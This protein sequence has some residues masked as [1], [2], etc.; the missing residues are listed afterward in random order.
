MDEDSNR[1]HLHGQNQP[2]F[3]KV[4]CVRLP[5]SSIEEGLAFYRDALGHAVLWRTETAVGL[6]LPDSN[7]ELVLQTLGHPPEVDLTVD[8]VSEAVSLIQAAGGELKTGPFEVMIGLC[9][10]VTDPWSNR[11]VIL[12]SSKGK[13]Q[14]DPDDN[15][16]PRG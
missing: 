15:V 16:V 13:L 14:T 12:D 8:S 11:L 9:A 6:A 2:L 10:I 7:A 4:D 3:S 1:R 5:V